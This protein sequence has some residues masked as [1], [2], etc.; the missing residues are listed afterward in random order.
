MV[1]PL[2]DQTDAALFSHIAGDDASA[3]RAAEREIYARHVR[4]LFGIINKRRDQLVK[5]AGLSVEDLVQ[6]TFLRAFDRAATYRGL[7]DTDE[8]RSRRR[9]RAWLGR[10]AQ[11]LIMDGFR[12]F[13]EVAA[14]D[15]LDQVT[16][17][18]PDS[19][20][21]SRPDL[22]PIQAAMETLTDREQ[23]ILR[24]TAMF[25]K[26]GK[27]GRLPND[28]SAELSKRWGISNDNL[29]AIRSRALKKLSRALEDQKETGR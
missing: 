27:P 23:D 15:F 6:D 22:A 4:Y 11:N 1:P 10:I 20:P 24:V 3:A 7:E 13:R 9:T 28:V 12:R 19:P 25:H 16:V 2:A 18:G 5:L 26:A 14:S 8:D 29:R 17:A 21:S